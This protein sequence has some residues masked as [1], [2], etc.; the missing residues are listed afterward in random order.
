MRFQRLDLNLLVALD[1]LLTER[2]VSQAADRINLTQSA[3]SN[4]LSRLREYFE[5]ELLVLKG[6]QMILTPRAEALAGPVRSVLAEI[7][8]TIAT[9]PAFEPEKCDRVIRIMASDYTIETLIGPTLTEISREAPSL[10]FVILP[11]QDE[12]NEALDRGVVDLI[13]SVDIVLSRDHPMRLITEDEFVVVACANNTKLTNREIDCELFFALGHIAVEFPRAQHLDDFRHNGVARRIDIVAPHFMAIPS[14]VLG[15]DRIAMM[16]RRLAQRAALRAPLRIMRPP[17]DTP[18]I[19][20]AAQWH[21][22][23]DKDPALRWVVDRMHAI[24]TRA[25]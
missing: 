9:P 3:T 18:P 20:Q 16:Q 11:I 12:V 13:L 17:F 7:R 5:D 24:A 14:L 2:N 23:S 15:S 10:R 4:A 8:D 1:A 6:R 19:R 25:S 22:S 21:R